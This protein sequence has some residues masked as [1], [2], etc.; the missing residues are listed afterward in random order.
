METGTAMSRH[1]LG[2]H[3]RQLRTTQPL[4]LESAAA[5]LG[6]APSTLSRIENGQSPTRLTYLSTLLDLYGVHDPLQRERLTEMAVAGRRKDWWAKY[7]NLLPA[8]TGT[9]LGLEATAE[10]VRGFAADAVPG[11]LQTRGYAEAFFKATRPELGT[12]EISGLVGLQLRRQRLPGHDGRRLDLILD[13]SVLLRSVGSPRVMA[14]QLAHLLVVTSEPSVT[15]RVIR[16]ATTRTVLGQSFTLV[17]LRADA[18]SV[19]ACLE[20]IGGQVDVY[21][22][23]ADVDAMQRMFGVLARSALSPAE[24]AKLIGRYV[25]KSR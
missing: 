2:M 23:A 11:L 6:I 20:G 15:V 14:D 12:A 18:E 24:S 21:R 19:I 9:Y 8:G 4:R 1:Q 10:R 3:L 22:R 13:E 16:L 5:K 7:A 25:D 17:H